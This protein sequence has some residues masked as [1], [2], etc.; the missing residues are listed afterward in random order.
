MTWN[1]YKK[2]SRSSCEQTGGPS[3]ATLKIALG[4]TM[5][6]PGTPSQHLWYT[7]ATVIV[8]VALTLTNAA[9]AQELSVEDFDWDTVSCISLF[10]FCVPTL[11][12]FFYRFPLL[13]N[14][15]GQRVIQFFSAQSFR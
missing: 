3:D 8:L 2:P 12:R 11:T 1:W 15:S 14:C 13:S 4:P 6:S 9:N 10:L 5:Q 7:L